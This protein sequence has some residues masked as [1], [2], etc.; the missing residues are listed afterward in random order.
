MLHRHWHQWYGGWNK[1]L[2]QPQQA[3]WAPHELWQDASVQRPQQGGV[4]PALE[5]CEQP[6]QAPRV[7]G[8]QSLEAAECETQLSLFGLH[9]G[10]GHQAPQEPQQ[11]PRALTAPEKRT[12]EEFIDEVGNVYAPETPRLS[13]PSPQSSDSSDSEDMMSDANCKNSRSID[14]DSEDNIEDVATE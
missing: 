4:H 11:A 10:I 5:Q 6:Q 8:E 14:I 3:P 7:P 12:L 1:A 13:P 9:Q 2:Q